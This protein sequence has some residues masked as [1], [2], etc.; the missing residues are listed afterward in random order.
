MW[1][2]FLPKHTNA[3]LKVDD[4][5]AIGFEIKRKCKVCGEVFLA[6]TLDSQYC[7]PKCSKVAWKRKKDAKEKNEKLNRLAQHIPDI[8]EYVSVKEAV[9]MFG[10]ERTTLYR[11]IKTGVIPAINVGQRLIRIKRSV[12][13]AMFLTRKESLAEKEKSVPKRYSMEPEDCYTIGEICSLYH[14]NDSTVW[15]HVRKYSIPSRQIGNYVYVPK[16]EI[17]NLYK[18]EVE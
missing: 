3:Y 10:V 7:S 8:R 13:E 12:M 18:S 5:P 11:L 1:D 6:K 16:E 17:D 15:A 9:A 14:I 4:M 2:L